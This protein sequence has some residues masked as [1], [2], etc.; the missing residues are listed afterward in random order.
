MFWPEPELALPL[1]GT[2][3]EGDSGAHLNAGWDK[4]RGMDSTPHT[5]PAAVPGLGWPLPGWPSATAPVPTA[6][7]AGTLASLHFSQIK[8]RLG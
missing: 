2:G 7:D 8:T 4:D 1:G 5:G 6:A 3:Q